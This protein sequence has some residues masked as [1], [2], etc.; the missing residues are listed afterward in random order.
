MA[1]YAALAQE[2]GIVPIVEPE[3]LMDGDHDAARCEEVTTFVHHEF[4]HELF[5][6]SILVNGLGRAAVSFGNLFRKLQS[7]ELQGY[8]YSFGL[9]VILVIYFTVFL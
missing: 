2:N 8:A 3:V 9:G 6:N 1:R 4:F 5:I 7:G